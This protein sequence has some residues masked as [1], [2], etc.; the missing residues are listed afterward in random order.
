MGDLDFVQ[1]VLDSTLDTRLLCFL[2]SR[3]AL[4]IVRRCQGDSHVM[5]AGLKAVIC[6]ES[7]GDVGVDL[8]FRSE[9]SSSEVFM[10]GTTAAIV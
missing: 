2:Q 5:M 9:E 4:R 3:Q 7:L 6:Q 8:A 10:N 1:E